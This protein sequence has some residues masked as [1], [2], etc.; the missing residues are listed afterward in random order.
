MSIVHLNTINKI[1]SLICA[2]YFYY[3]LFSATLQASINF[4]TTFH[5]NK[6]HKI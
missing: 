4:T 3:Y 2:L 1:Y 5:N 6:K